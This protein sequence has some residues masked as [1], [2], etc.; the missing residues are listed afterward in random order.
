ARAA[1]TVTAPVLLR[2]GHPKTL[3]SPMPSPPRKPPAA[4]ALRDAM[5]ACRNCELWERATQ[6]VPGEGNG[7][8]TIMLVGEQPGD[9]ED[10]A[11]HPFIGPAGKLVD[12]PLAGAGV[13]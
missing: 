9:Q 10:L 7:H 2:Q 11:G 13:Q 12:R 5:N 6:A 8:A 1:S 3:P 4:P